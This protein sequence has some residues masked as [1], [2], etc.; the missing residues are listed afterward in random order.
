MIYNIQGHSFFPKTIMEEM[1]LAS[2]VIKACSIIYSVFMTVQTQNITLSE[3]KNIIFHGSL[4]MSFDLFGLVQ[5]NQT[6]SLLSI[7]P[8]RR[9]PP[10][11]RNAQTTLPLLYG[12]S[13]MGSLVIS[14]ERW[15]W[16][17]GGNVWASWGC[18]SHVLRHTPMERKIEQ[19]EKVFPMWTTRLHFFS[20]INLIQKATMSQVKQINLILGT[21]Q[22]FS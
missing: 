1:S 7:C 19:E 4:L 11:L 5:D 12:K 17:P 22:V 3:V 20:C 2:K 21:K 18:S 6:H 15:L 9:M 14:I 8:N 10:H 16:L 13:V